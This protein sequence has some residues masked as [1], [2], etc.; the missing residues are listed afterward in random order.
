MFGWKKQKRLLKIWDVNEKM[1]FCDELQ[2]LELPEQLILSLSKE[3]YN[4]PNPCEIH[5]SAV[6]TRVFMEFEEVLRVGERCEMLTLPERLRECI[7][8]EAVTLGIFKEDNV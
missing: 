7:P 6:M 5:R 4:D 8:N 2:T 1:L 3:F